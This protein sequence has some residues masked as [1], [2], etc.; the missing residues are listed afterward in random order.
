MRLAASIALAVIVFAGVAAAQNG[1]TPATGGQ[2]AGPSAATTGQGE[3]QSVP[4]PH[5]QPR[6]L[7]EQPN[8]E[9]TPIAPIDR[10]LD[11]RLTICQHC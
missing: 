8:S 9:Q 10:D 7:A 5:R 2:A 1:P 3:P 11:R 4:L 6:A